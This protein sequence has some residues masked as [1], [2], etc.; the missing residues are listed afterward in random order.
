MKEECP[1]DCPCEP[2]G[3]RSNTISLT[4]LDEVEINGFG[5]DDHEVDFLKLMFKCAP[6]LK[7]LT[8]KLSHEASSCDGCTKLYNITKAC[9]SVELYVY[10]SSGEYV[11]HA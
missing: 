1:F 6:M 11:L 3:W 5:G 2:E 8:V 4:A 9:S 10:L 7:K